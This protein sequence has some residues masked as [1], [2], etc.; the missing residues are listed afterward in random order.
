VAFSYAEL[1]I[2]CFRIMNPVDGTEVYQDSAARE[3]CKRSWQ[4]ILV[5]MDTIGFNRE[6][7]M[8][9][10]NVITAGVETD[11]HTHRQ[12]HT[13]VHQFNGTCQMQLVAPRFSSCTYSEPDKLLMS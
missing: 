6:V 9:A 12:T 8:R 7:T 13:R 3:H 5:I 11:R 2:L 4:Q 1:V 10:D